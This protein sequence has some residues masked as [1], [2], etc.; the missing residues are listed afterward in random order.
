VL[1]EKCRRFGSFTAR[2]HDTV[3]TAM[4]CGGYRHVTAQRSFGSAPRKR[5]NRGGTSEAI[6]GTRPYD[7]SA[8]SD[9]P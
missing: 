8:R 7:D 3:N 2:Q 4:Q 1:F 5:P 9:V 6:P